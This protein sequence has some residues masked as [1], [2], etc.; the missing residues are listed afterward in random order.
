MTFIVMVLLDYVVSL[1]R[2]DYVI[3]VFYT[4]YI[5]V[6]VIVSAIG[7]IY[8]NRRYDMYS[9]WYVTLSLIAWSFG[10]RQIL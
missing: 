10:V 4:V 9:S 8:K 2:D 7:I 6:Y 1:I 3:D 5:A